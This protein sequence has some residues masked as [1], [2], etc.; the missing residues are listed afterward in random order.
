MFEGNQPS[1]K[2]ENSLSPVLICRT[3]DGTEYRMF[4]HDCDLSTG[5]FMKFS[6]KLEKVTHLFLSV[7]FQRKV[8]KHRS[9]RFMISRVLEESGLPCTT[10]MRYSFEL[11][12]SYKTGSKLKPANQLPAFLVFLVKGH[13]WST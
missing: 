3:F 2:K 6:S 12:W 7:Q 13:G 10:Q 9:L 11:S 8:G 1:T 5:I 4:L